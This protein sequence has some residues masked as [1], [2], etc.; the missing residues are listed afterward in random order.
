MQEALQTRRTGRAAHRFAAD[1]LTLSS[2]PADAG[3]VSLEREV[4]RTRAALQATV[5]QLETAAAALR[6]LADERKRSRGAER[7][8]RKEDEQKLTREFDEGLRAAEIGLL[9]LDEN[10]CIRRFT[11]LIGE[12][13]PIGEA[14]IGR[15]LSDIRP[16]FPDFDLAAMIARV[17]R[18]RGT[19]EAD[20]EDAALRNWRLRAAC[21]GDSKGAMLAM[22]SLDGGAGESR[23]RNRRLANAAPYAGD[24]VVV[25]DPETGRVLCAN[26]RAQVAYGLPDGPLEIS[27]LTP[28]WGT[29]TWIAWL[30][31][32]APGASSHRADV[33]VLDRSGALAS[34][35]LRATRLRD[36]D[37]PRALVRI[38]ESVARPDG[39]TA[40]RELQQR[41]RQLA[42]SN[43]ELERFAS[44]VAHDL[45]AP[46]RHMSQF[47]EILVGALGPEADGSALRYLGLIKSSASK[48]SVMIERLLDYA[49]IGVGAPKLEP[50]D[51]SACFK[52]ACEV[53]GAQT[54]FVGI[55]A[56]FGAH[57]W[58]RG[59]RV[60]LNRLFQNLIENALK[61][62]KPGAAPRLR[63]TA[64]GEGANIF[65]AFEDDG[66][67]VDPGKAE[68]IFEMF[69]RETTTSGVAGDGIGL[70]VCRRICETM[71][72]AIA[73]DSQRREGA[74]FLVRL[75][76]ATPRRAKS[77][78]ANSPVETG[79]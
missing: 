49:R 78:R 76:R 4:R 47:A 64:A 74:R 28:D 3:V 61:Y 16:P 57:G 33:V 77:G 18:R 46:L 30:N 27:R 54:K 65:I 26:T 79:A 35:D 75:P 6:S 59:D 7:R 21:L 69:G 17:V 40:L 58:A 51:L 36:E 63:V 34:V 50:V 72:G 56:A 60:L 66:I 45:R 29:P 68:A 10:A 38:V 71:G 53:L 12:A 43:R 42:I 31:A 48:L 37:R 2:Q 24:A 32:I 13:L 25:V 20:V 41:A 67:G 44:V 23:D 22:I 62:H 8:R 1:G 5:E 52:E 19:E 9:H 11:R 73:L 14:D 70:A 55:E 15:S 39:A